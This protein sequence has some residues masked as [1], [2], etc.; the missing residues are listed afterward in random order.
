M[1]RA[2]GRVRR[3]RLR[4]GVR[5]GCELAKRRLDVGPVR[6]A[7][8]DRDS[9]RVTPGVGANTLED[10]DHRWAQGC[11]KSPVF[12]RRI[13]PRFPR[14]SPTFRTTNR[15]APMRGFAACARWWDLNPAY[16]DAFTR[17]WLLR[18]QGEIVG[19]LGSIPWKFQLGGQRNDG[20]RRD[21]LA[22]AAGIPG[23][24][25]R[26]E[27]PADGRARGCAAFLHD[28]ARG[29]RAAVDAARLRADAQREGRR[30]AQRHHPRTSRSCCGRSSTA[31]RRPRSSRNAP[32]R[33]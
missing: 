23:H 10:V 30:N 1:I 6:L 28:A 14:S 27:A 15:A 33:R 22:G 19:F 2:P 7:S 29:S 21:H 16:D 26:P 25:H 18:E 32:R 4:K 12:P 17:G 8:H 3:E 20:V 24:E 5:F 11:Q 9:L 31:G 13:T